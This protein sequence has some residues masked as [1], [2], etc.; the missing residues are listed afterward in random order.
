MRVWSSFTESESSMPDKRVPSRR[1]K[2]NQGGDNGAFLLRLIGIL[3]DPSR[4]AGTPLQLNA[5]AIEYVAIFLE[6]GEPPPPGMQRS[7][8]QLERLLLQV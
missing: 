2:A 6:K 1:T 5:A 7:A 4:S 3:E 8:R